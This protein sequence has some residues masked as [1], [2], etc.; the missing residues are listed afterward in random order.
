MN[1]P[2]M[3]IEK[4]KFISMAAWFAGMLIVIICFRYIKAMLVYVL[5]KL[6]EIFIQRIPVS[7]DYRN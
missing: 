7:Y 2:A 6:Y 3:N 5:M 1:L 4:I